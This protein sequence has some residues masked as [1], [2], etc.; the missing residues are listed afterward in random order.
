MR[1]KA[2]DWTCQ[3]RI[4]RCDV[5]GHKRPATKRKGRTVAGH[6]KNM[7]CPWCKDTTEHTQ[8]E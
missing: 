4:F 7:W 8:T 1:Q 6:K 2:K 3:V 5:C